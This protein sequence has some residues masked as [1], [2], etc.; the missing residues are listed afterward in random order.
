MLPGWH[1]PTVP[2][3]ARNL[4]PQQ[5]QER[6]RKR[7]TNHV[8]RPWLRLKWN[9]VG[10]HEPRNARKRREH[11][12]LAT[13][14]A[15]QFM[16]I[17]SMKLIAVQS[18]FILQ[19]KVGEVLSDLAIFVM[20]KSRSTIGRAVSG[21]GLSWGQSLVVYDL[22]DLSQNGVYHIPEYTHQIAHFNG[23]ERI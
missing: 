10:H 5:G 17:P 19:E 14:S 13:S 6:P 20:P 3:D 2:G 9:R 4:E 15:S 7:R 16:T 1:S 12:E 18:R 23:I 8:P 22:M 11:Q 21:G